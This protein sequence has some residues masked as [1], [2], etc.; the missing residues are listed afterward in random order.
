[1]KPITEP[2]LAVP[3]ADEIRAQVERMVASEVFCRSVQLGAFLRFIVESV[4][5]GKGDRIKAYTVG[6][7]VLRRDDNFDPQIDPIVRVEATRL[8]YAIDRYY[9]GPGRDDPV[10]IDVPRGSYVPTFRSREGIASAEPP[11]AKGF[12]QYFMALRRPWAWTSIG[13]AVVV[14][15]AAIFVYN[16]I[17][18]P[19]LSGS[20]GS[21]DIEAIS[22]SSLLAGN[23]MPTLE[24]PKFEILGAPDP[25]VV[26]GDLLAEKLRDAL[27]RFDAINIVSEP[28]RGS[29]RV[30]YRLLGSIDYHGDTTTSV[31]VRLQDVGDGN[32]VWTRAFERLSLSRDRSA[33]E[34]QIVLEL[35]GTLL[36]PYGLIRSRERAKYLSGATG[37]PRYE[38][39]L[40]TGD[41]FRSF[42]PAEH[43]I[44]RRCLE[45]LIALSPSFDQGFSY[46]ASLINREFVYG[47][48][49]SA[50]DAHALDRALDLA[51]RGVEL[52]PT[53]ARSMQVLSAVLFS[54]RETEA[55]F[56]AVERAMGLNKYDLVI[57]GEFGGRLVTSGQIERGRK[58]LEQVAASA[59]VLPSWHHFYLFLCNYLTD[60]FARAAVQAAEMTSDT[61]P[62]GLL[63]RTLAAAATSRPDEARRTLAKL[64][65]LRPAWRDDARGELEKYIQAPSIVERLARDLKAAGLEH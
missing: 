44:A 11:E 4:L 15:A 42:N 41:A 34:D 26:S 57:L 30:D 38:C 54:R 63:A 53:S 7:E 10:I 55:A 36:Q 65:V 24:V 14:S 51:R 28:L 58:V 33:A 23:G 17:Q 62:H 16:F 8:R 32:A 13:L 46:L 5:H 59:N 50:D 45:W 48:G 60:D 39:L 43:D 56:G 19:A 61:Y 52:N 9:S 35:A 47:F 40:L 21:R 22:K 27:T 2:I 31:R 12:D 1:M 29:D 37:D 25:G 20:V 49:K 64:V 6:V 3:P 18:Q